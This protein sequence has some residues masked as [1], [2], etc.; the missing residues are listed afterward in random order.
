MLKPLFQEIV[1][2]IPPQAVSAQQAELVAN[3]VR[4]VEEASNAVLATTLFVN[5]LMRASFSQIW[6]MINSV[7]IIAYMTLLSLMFPQNSLDFFEFVLNL[8]EFDILPID[9]LTAGMFPFLKDFVHD[10]LEPA[11]RKL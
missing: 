1:S 10:Y 3:V 9:D 6:G 8:S 7:Q 11:S 4:S 5:L 2:E